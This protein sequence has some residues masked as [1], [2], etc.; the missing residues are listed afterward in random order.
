MNTYVPNNSASKHMKQK[1]IKLQKE[2]DELTTV[3]EDFSIPLTKSARTSD[4]KITKTIKD[5]I[6]TMN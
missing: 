4:H 3:V 5:L 2:I 6:A 1:L